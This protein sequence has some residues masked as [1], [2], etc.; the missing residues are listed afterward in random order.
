LRVRGWGAVA[1][2]VNNAT[3]R[4]GFPT[5]PNLPLSSRFTAGASGFLTFS[6]GVE[7]IE[8]PGFRSEGIAW[9]G[10]APLARPESKLHRPAPLVSRFPSSAAFVTWGAISLSISSVH[11]KKPHCGHRCRPQPGGE[12]PSLGNSSTSL[13]FSMQGV[14]AG[15]T[16]SRPM[17]EMLLISLRRICQ[18]LSAAISDDVKRVPLALRMLR[19]VLHFH[20]SSEPGMRSGRAN[21]ATALFC[22]SQWLSGTKSRPWSSRWSLDDFKR[23]DRINQFGYAEC[24]NV[25]VLSPCHW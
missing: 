11:R 8:A 2:H 7:S 4:A 16:S 19:Y 15:Q 5:C 3:A 25:G 22:G 6:Q 20:Q 23:S 12:G 21:G 13:R 24:F 17:S 18:S 14:V 10:P 1:V 9:R